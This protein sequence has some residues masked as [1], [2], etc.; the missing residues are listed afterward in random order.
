[1]I[2]LAGIGANST[3]EGF[4]IVHFNFARGVVGGQVTSFPVRLRGP[5]QLIL[6]AVGYASH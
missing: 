1:M 6:L 3:Y 2:L 4:P 5:V